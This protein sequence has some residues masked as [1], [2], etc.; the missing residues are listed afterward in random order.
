[1]AMASVGKASTTSNPRETL[2][3]PDRDDFSNK[4]IGNLVTEI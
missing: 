1:M 3:N 2:I 4:A